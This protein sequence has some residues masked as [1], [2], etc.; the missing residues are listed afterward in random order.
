MAILPNTLP[1]AL[2][3]NFTQLF[4]PFHPEPAHLLRYLDF[5]RTRTASSHC[6]QTHHILP[7]S[8]FPEYKSL[9]R[10]PWNGRKMTA[11][12]HTVAHYLLHLALPANEPMRS[13]FTQMAGRYCHLLRS[14]CPSEKL[15]RQ[16]NREYEAALLGGR[17]ATIKGWKRIYDA[18]GKGTA[19]P[20]AELEARILAG[21]TVVA[22]KREWMYRGREQKR[23]LLKDVP[24]HSAK[25]F[26]LG[27]P[28]LPE[29]TRGRMSESQKCRY[30]RDPSQRLKGKL[31]GTAHRRFGKTLAREVRSKI[32]QSLAGA[33][34]SPGTI[35]KRRKSLLA[36]APIRN[37]RIRASRTEERRSAWSLAMTGTGNNRYGKTGAWAGKKMPVEMKARMAA[38]HLANRQ[39]DP[40]MYIRNLPRGERHWTFG[41]SRPEATRSKIA[42]SLR[43]KMQSPETREKRSLA[44]AMKK[45]PKLRAEEQA[46]LRL[47]AH[48]KTQER[49]ALLQQAKRPPARLI[50]KGII[51]ILSGANL[52]SNRRYWRTAATWMRINSIESFFFEVVG[53]I[54]RHN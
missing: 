30:S 52:E 33:V 39:R 54:R 43:G 2:V 6:T 41:K 36:N 46:L 42:A 34:Q 16:I 48:T 40:G 24:L 11:A 49:T 47:V 22:P 4:D 19:V 45:M 18:S 37:A 29:E 51:L 8:L 20:P 13:A 3:D 44:L 27:R 50:A 25:G 21:W 5:V 15:L 38:S 28:F 53:I 26:V 35:A 32:S 31:C 14:Q 9:A 7:I 1:T 10:F 17:L 23:V 12:D